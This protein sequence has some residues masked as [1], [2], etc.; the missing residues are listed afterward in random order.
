MISEW[1]NNFRLLS[2]DYLGKEKGFAKE[3]S[4][5]SIPGCLL[6][7]WLFFQPDQ[8]NLSL[9]SPTEIYSDQS[10]HFFSTFPGLSRALEK[11]FINDQ[12]VKTLS[13]NQQ[14]KDGA[15]KVVDRE[16]P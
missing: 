15:H 8:T 3:T 16:S 2:T 1:R 11:K 4:Q 10:D 7:T 6:Q 9:N 14:N 12:V 13:R 5:W